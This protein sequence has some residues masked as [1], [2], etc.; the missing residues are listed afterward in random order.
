[1]PGLADILP[2]GILR[3]L[4]PPPQPGYVRIRELDLAALMRSEGVIALDARALLASAEADL[5]ALLARTAPGD[6]AEELRRAIAETPQTREEVLRD[7]IA[8]AT[9]VEAV[10]TR[11]FDGSTGTY[12]LSPYEVGYHPQSGR[13][14]LWATVDDGTGAQPEGATHPGEPHDGTIHAFLYDRIG[15][16]TPTTARFFPLWPL[17]PDSV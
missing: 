7:A 16:V 13:T 17:Q 8:T 4:L 15:T 2:S 6:V 14:V 10:Y 12:R 9:K 1:M 11:K 3:G 5:A